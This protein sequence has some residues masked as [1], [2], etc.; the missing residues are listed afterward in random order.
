[1]MSHQVVNLLLQAFC[2]LPLFLMA[3][4][5]P[6]GQCRQERAEQDKSENCHDVSPRFGW[7][8]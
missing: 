4:L 8:A 2:A 3:V 1:M 5:A 6:D 7:Y